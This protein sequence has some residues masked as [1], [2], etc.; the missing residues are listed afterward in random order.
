MGIHRQ[1]ALVAALLVCASGTAAAQGGSQAA[2]KVGL[3]TGFPAGIGIQWHLSD[4]VAIRPEI[5][6][7]TSS[8]ETAT[9]SFES[10]GDSWT[11]STHISALFYLS[12][13]DRL[14][15][16]VS[17][18]FTWSHASSTNQ[19]SSALLNPI[20][21]VTTSE[22]TTTGD[23]YGLA[24]SFGAQYGLGDRFVVFGELGLSYAHATTKLSTIPTKSTTNG[25]GTRAAG[26]I[27][28]YP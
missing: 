14:R 12:T 16:Y 28:F 4:K 8:T 18:R 19:L 22:S 26:G 11:I 24:G 1:L 9:N 21:G 25:F 17:P 23:G 2:G 6:F 20:T 7:S 10:E 3:T 13:D 5:T 27:V 15:T